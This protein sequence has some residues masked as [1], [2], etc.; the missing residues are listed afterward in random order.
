MRSDPFAI[1]DQLGRR[2]R[3]EVD[4]EFARMGSAP[5]TVALVE[6]HHS[7]RGGVEHAPERRRAARSR[8]TVQYHR[9][10]A[11]GIAADLPIEMVTVS[12]IEHPDVVRLYR[13]VH[14]H[15]RELD[16]AC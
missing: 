13:W 14:L 6:L 9:G 5:A 3:R 15:R 16:M 8:P 2:V 1:I 12:D 10:L 4:I 11:I 7:V